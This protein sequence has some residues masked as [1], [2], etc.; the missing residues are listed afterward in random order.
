MKVLEKEIQLRDETRTAEQTKAAN[1]QVLDADETAQKHHQRSLALADSQ[2]GLNDRIDVVV[3]KILSLPNSDSFGKELALLSRVSELMAEATGILTR[4]ETGPEAIAC[5]TEIIEL[6]L[7]TRRIQPKA[8]G[9]GGG[10]TPGGG[11]GG[12]T[13]ASALAL[14]G[15]GAD[16]NAHIAERQVGQATGEAGRELPAEF[17]AGLDAYFNA[18][19]EGR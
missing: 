4:P 2:E 5:E 7:Q 14:V 12:T 11:G 3:E 10:S 17:R 6:L 1:A 15:T 8:G 9:G 18:L 19:E 16:E 13:E